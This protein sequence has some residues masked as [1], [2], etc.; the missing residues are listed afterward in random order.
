MSFYTV[1]RSLAALSTTADLMTLVSA[2]N[3]RTKVHSITIGGLATASAANSVMVQ[4]SSAGV[5]PGGAITPEKTATDA[6]AAATVVNTTYATAPTLAGSPLLRLPVNSNGG[7]IRWTAY[8]GRELEI[9]NGEMLSLRSE[10]G[11]GNVTVAIEFEE[12]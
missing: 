5:T 6:P 3:R 7:V 10:T 2:A 12:V 8:P 4:R 11:T 1:T 9:R